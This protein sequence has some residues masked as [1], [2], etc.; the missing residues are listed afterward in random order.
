ME[1]CFDFANSTSLNQNI[2]H[3]PLLEK[4]SPQVKSRSHS[5]LPRQANRFYHYILSHNVV[6]YL[7]I[8]RHSVL[9]LRL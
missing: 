4:D 2:V 3:G 6:A 5:L 1:L 9:R 7:S 8:L